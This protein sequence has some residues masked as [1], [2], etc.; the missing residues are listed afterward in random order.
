MERM[1]ALIRQSLEA[2]AQDVEPTPA[3]WLEV[4][5]RVARRKRFQVVSWSLAGVTA[6]LA[7]VLAVPAMV[8][9]LSGPDTIEIPPLD[10]TPAAGV[11]STHVVAIDAEGTASLVDLRT[12][13][14]VRE[15]VSL[16]HAVADLAVSPTSTRD[17]VEFAAISVSGELTVVGPGGE[18][19]ASG[20]VD[21]P[22]GFGWSVVAAPDG[23]WFASTSPTEQDDGATVTVVPSVTSWTPGDDVTWTE[24]GMIVDQGSRLVAW[25]GDT[26]AEGDR[27]TLWLITGEGTLVREVLEVV[28]GVPTSLEM[29]QADDQSWQVLDA[30]TSFAQAGADGEASYLLVDGASGPELVWRGA[31]GSVSTLDLAA[32]VGEVDPA[33][34]WLD[35]KQDA[36]LVGDGERTWLFAHDGRGSFAAPTALPDG[37]VRA[38]LL[39]VDRPGRA[40]VDEPEDEPAEEPA[41]PD[42]AQPEGPAV[43]GT[44]LAAPIVTVSLRELVLHGP[45]GAQPLYTLP[46]EGES[47]FVSARVR[48]GSTQDDLTVVALVRAEGML[49][50]REYRWD[51][52]ELTWDYLPDHLQPGV[53]D[54]AEAGPQA[55][56]PVWSPDGAYLAWFE[57]GTGAA[58]TLRVIGWTDEGPGTGEPATDN[59]SFAIDTRGNVPLL[60]SEWVATPGAAAATELRASALDS[61]EGWYALPVDLQADG[62]VAL[63]T[64]SFEVRDPGLLDGVILGVASDATSSPRWYV[65]STSDGAWLSEPDGPPGRAR[66]VGLPSTLLPGD[67]LVELWV[68]AI[69]DGALVGSHDTATAYY[70]DRDGTPNRIAGEVVDADIVR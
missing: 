18:R 51:G 13:A 67:G 68:R 56:G 27:S 52:S 55:H 3:L 16:D 2:R 23:R 22:D 30:T 42:A 15:L 43:A 59:A 17:A 64:G 9:L 49:D 50:L 69:G 25:T 47:T 41:E 37:T 21:A 19:W 34:L 65:T 29:G 58:P 53:G 63:P 24:V 62:A 10:R 45:E 70:V 46:T 57:F 14:A 4:D 35:A 28:D 39:D 1:E 48:P 40:P 20:E 38:G 36:A 6:V 8:G 33:E 60:P 26:T 11:V 54:D 31:D 7:A 12:G 66:G 61:N 32:V 44:P 5:R